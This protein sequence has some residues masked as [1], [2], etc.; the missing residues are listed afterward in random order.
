LKDI[1]RYGVIFLGLFVVMA[2]TLA[3]FGLNVGTSLA[4]MRDGAMG[5]SISVGRTLVKAT[6]L[7]LAGLGIV[8]AWRAG[9]YNI[10]GEGQY[11][12]GGI[13]GAAC[14]KVL[15]GLF[16]P[17]L[18]PVILI[19]G[20]LFGAVLGAL[21]GWL[22][23]KRGV[24]VVI[25]TILMNSLVLLTLEW[26][27]RGPLQEK[28]KQIFVTDALPDAV[29]LMRFDRQSDLHAGVFLAVIAVIVV[30]IFLRFTEAGFKLR[31]VGESATAAQANKIDVGRIQIRA[32]AM[33][34]GLC[35]LAGAVDYA[36]LTGRLADGF[37]QNWGFI[38]IPVALLGGLN[39]WGTLA[40]ALYFGGLFAG[41]DNLKRFTPIGNSLVPAVQGV[42]VLAFIGL[43]YWYSRRVERQAEGD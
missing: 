5:D 31:V 3:A 36:G 20:A 18:S 30:W 25:S 2:L 7:C 1:L 4:F 19:C 40:S 26:L 8:I 14:A 27:L 15:A 33:S 21:A 43:N 39:P 37:G 32:M 24:Q 29:R 34:G 12:F 13:G 22:H 28:K 41:S 38:A 16:A 23:V 11:V 9:M 6:P 17:V 10:G 42:A 35:G